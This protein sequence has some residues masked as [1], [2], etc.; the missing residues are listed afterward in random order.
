ML[1]EVSSHRLELLSEA[2]TYVFDPSGSWD[3]LH[4]DVTGGGRVRVRIP[5]HDFTC[6]GRTEA[7]HYRPNPE[8]PSRWN[9]LSFPPRI[10]CG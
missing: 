1:L 7:L 3:A 9:S 2:R 5:H 10:R 6:R 4:R 8:D